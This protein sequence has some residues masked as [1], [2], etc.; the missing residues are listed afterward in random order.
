[1]NRQHERQYR[2]YR[3]VITLNRC[4]DDMVHLSTT[5][6]E[7]E[8]DLPGP[9]L[10]YMERFHPELLV[11]ALQRIKAAIDARITR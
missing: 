9:S 4:A 10:D 1:M 7:R 6:C 3:I 8:S 11:D 5:T 2:G